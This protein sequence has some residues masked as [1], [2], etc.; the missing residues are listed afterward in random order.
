MHFYIKKTRIDLG[1]PFAA[2]AAVI[3]M[4]DK[5]GT[6]LLVF[7]FAVFCMRRGIFCS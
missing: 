6:A 7:F 3:L 1:F 2:S 4:L 5:S